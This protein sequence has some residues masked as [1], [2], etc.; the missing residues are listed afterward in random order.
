MA[1]G[2]I[3]VPG[4]ADSYVRRDAAGRFEGWSLQR[5]GVGEPD[6]C[7]GCVGTG[8]LLRRWAAVRVGD[9][10]SQVEGRRSAGVRV[11]V[12]TGNAQPQASEAGRGREAISVAEATSGAWRGGGAW[13]WRR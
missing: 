3:C 2:W 8:W 12:R 9:F 7:P 10:R 5:D 4:A 1:A 11:C 13:S 6:R